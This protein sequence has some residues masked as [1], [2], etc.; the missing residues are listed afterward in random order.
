[1]TDE[2]RGRRIT[3]WT[4]F[5]ERSIELGLGAAML[6]AEGAQRLVNDM[7]NRGEVAREESTGLV[8]RLI[9]IGREQQE[10]LRETIEKTTERVMERMNVAKKDEVAALRQRVDDL[11]RIVMSR[12]APASTEPPPPSTLQ[13][14][15]FQIDQE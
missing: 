8:D 4:E 15:D 10:M 3:N 6:T 13:G 7:V 2:T 14:E 12:T 9:V 5:I 11:E 1:M